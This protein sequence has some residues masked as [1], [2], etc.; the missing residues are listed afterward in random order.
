MP[1]CGPG[2]LE[3]VRVLLSKRRIGPRITGR[4]RAPWCRL[5]TELQDS[6][7]GTLACQLH[8]RSRN[9]PR[10]IT[11]TV[12]A[13]Q[14]STAAPLNLGSPNPRGFDAHLQPIMRPDPRASVC[15]HA[16]AMLRLRALPCPMTYAWR[17]LTASLKVHSSVL[18]LL[19]RH[20]HV[21]LYLHYHGIQHQPHDGPKTQSRPRPTN[22]P[23][24]GGKPQDTQGRTVTRRPSPSPGLQAAVV[25]G[26]T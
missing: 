13:S 3:D 18:R 6:A 10:S 5:H 23:L 15:V 25:G 2:M 9:P 22:V 4:L 14:P 12:K 20:S 1:V 21:A 11:T 19:M 16:C 24:S 26:C 8:H 7:K 17:Q